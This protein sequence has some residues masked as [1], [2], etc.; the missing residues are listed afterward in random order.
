[1]R[2]FGKKFIPGV[3]VEID[4][5]QVESKKPKD[6]DIVS[7]HSEQ[8]TA[9]TY[10]PNSEETTNNECD[11]YDE[12][13]YETALESFEAFTRIRRSK[14][15][16]E[17]LH[18]TDWESVNY[19]LTKLR[20]NEDEITGLCVSDQYLIAQYHIE[21]GI[22]VYDRVTLKHLY[23]LNGHEYGGQCV[24]ISGKIL[25]SASMDFTLKVWNLETQK[26]TDT[27]SDH[28]D[29][30]QCLAI[31][32]GDE[33][34][35]IAT[36]GKGDREIF[37]YKSS[38]L[39]KLTKTHCLRGHTGW[40]IQLIFDS[41]DHLVSGS[42]DATI[43]LWDLISGDVIHVIPQDT[44]ISCLVA[45]KLKGQ[46]DDVVLF[47]DRD[48]KMSYLDMQTL[49]VHH[50]LPNILIG[51]GKYCRS[52]KYH[53]KSVDQANL[54]ENGYLVTGSEGS[55]YLKIW[56]IKTPLEYGYSVDEESPDYDLEQT[57][58]RELQI[59][60][61]HSDYLTV[62]KVFGNTIYSS[63]SDGEIYMHSFPDEGQLPH[64][65]MAVDADDD[66]ASAVML[67]KQG[68]GV[69]ARPEKPTELCLGPGRCQTGKTGIVKSSSSFQVSFS[70][71]PQIVSV[72]GKIKLLPKHEV[73]LEEDDEEWDPD[74]ENSDSSDDDCTYTSDDSDS[75]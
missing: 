62:V 52:S 36:G 34:D 63:C 33:S 27:A 23:R 12:D 64:Y 11:D 61:D 22:D 58:V 48:G 40:I 41:E 5:D 10:E 75:D 20:C 47:G 38:K 17:I 15:D 53:D 31:K 44:G 45:S 2:L 57:E 26:M 1:M 24:E 32:P 56:K 54:T 51:T 21:G 7:N 9:T 16:E 74:D 3:R 39:G 8:S 73:I 68:S 66:T 60:R 67:D 19:S 35:V 6:L 71:K 72:D 42:E 29:Y 30:V 59:L 18:G 69:V 37:V 13:N 65:E 49:T 14:A 70:F 50:L 4:A 46:E 55:K 28:C 25:Y 43:R